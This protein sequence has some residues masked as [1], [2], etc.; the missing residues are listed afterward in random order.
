[1]TNKDS[2]F[3]EIMGP[4]FGSRK[5]ERVTGDRFY[6][7]D[8]KIWYVDLGVDGGLLSVVSVKRKV[9]KNIYA[10]NGESLKSILT[11]LKPLV[12]ASIVTKV[13]EDIYNEAGY[14]AQDNGMKRYVV[15]VGDK[16][17][18]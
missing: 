2:G 6:D 15:I 14:V 17:A 7:D 5:V 13:Y 3:Y 4:V 9:I 16:N 10:E 1:M 12:K 8:D 18:E 11:E